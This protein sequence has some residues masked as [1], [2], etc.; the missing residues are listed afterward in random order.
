MPTDLITG[1]RVAIVTEAGESLGATLKLLRS[2]A[3]LTQEELA[4]RSGISARTISDLERGLRGTVYP[5]TARRLAAALGLDRDAS[6]RF[7]ATA[8]RRTSSEPELPTHALPIPPTPLLGRADEV[9]RILSA[10]REPGLRL[11]TL[12]GPGGIGKTRLALAV[13]GIEQTS[14]PDGVFFVPL[15]EVRD[16]EL[17][18]P[19][20]AKALGVAEIGAGIP[21]LIERWL[22]GRQA[23]IVLDTFEQ[24][25]P[26]ALLVSSMIVHAP[27]SK[28]LVT[29]RRRLNVRGEHEIQV[30]PLD[31][32]WAAALFEARVQASGHDPDLVMEICRQLDGLPLAIELAAARTKHLGLAA[33]ASQL[34]NRLGLLT[35]G[36]VDL[37]LRQ[38]AIRETV[39]WSHDLLEESERVLFRRLAAFSGG[40]TLASAAEVCDTP[41][42][43]VAMSGLIEQS[44]VR[45]ARSGV[46]PRYGMLDVI[47]EYAA[48]RLEESTAQRHALHHLELA[49]EGEVRLVGARQA[50]W[51]RLLDA[52]RGNLRRAIA[53][54]LRQPDSVFALRFTVALWRYWRYSG[55]FAEG[56]RWSE[57]ALAMPGA[58]PTSLR[59]KA[60]WGTAFLAYPQGDYGRMAELAPECLEMARQGGDPMDLRNALTVTG[61]LAMCEGRY[62][63]AIEPLREALEMCRRL[64]LSWQLGTSHL[65]YG[66]AP[67]HSGHPAEAERIYRDGLEVYRELGDA[68]FAARMTNAIAHVALARDDVDGADDLARDALRGFAGQRERIGIAEALDTLA[69]VAA[70]RADADRAARLDGASASIHETIASRPAPFERAIT[71]QFIKGSHV[72]VGEN[73][74]R[75]AWEAGHGLSLEEAVDYAL[76]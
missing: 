73:R 27:G 16:S 68:T 65:N 14:F 28:F 29:S 71:G 59:A 46:E 35:G 12:T 57:A 72:A 25:L 36:P 17:V 40:W 11:I 41:E 20:I 42:P 49:E 51:Y 47:H 19:A 34:N 55:E 26:A 66:S 53:W 30:P 38:Q 50:E 75:S 13:A 31:L 8:A 24:L 58:A 52:E 15:G 22:A 63:D 3:R 32:T 21:V 4:D 9:A 39:A 1:W 76:S 64:G 18:A 43:L 74:W 7:E 45:M 56:R 67:L 54:A 37:P 2:T 69:A 6:H 10:S 70:A 5:H 60:L 61:Q 33:L 44:L 48:E 62:N 23:M